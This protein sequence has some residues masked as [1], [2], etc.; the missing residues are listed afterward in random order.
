MFSKLRFKLTLTNVIV[1]SIIFIIFVMSIYI[2]MSRIVNDQTEQLANLIASN[3]GISN[4]PEKD[5]YT[6]HGE[7]QYRYFY[8][9]LDSTGKII[10]ASSNLNLQNSPRLSGIISKAF[11]AKGSKGVV[12]ADEETYQFLKSTVDNSNDTFIAFVNTHAEHEMLNE[13]LVVLMLAGLGGLILVFFGSLYM[14]NRSLIPIKEAW[15]RQKAFVADASHELRTPLSVIETT[16]D[17][18]SNRRENTI[19]SQMKWLENIQTENKRMTKLVSDLLLLARADS[20]QDTL[21]LKTFP[22]HTALLEAYI[23]FEAIAL[24]KGIHLQA[25]N[26]D[27][28]DFY[29]DEAKIKQLAVILVDNGIKYTPTGGCVGMTL[30]NSSDSVEI[31]VT[32]SGEG[33]SEE[34]IS[35]IFQRFY[36]IDKSRSRKDGSVGLG[37]SIAEWIVKQHSGHINVESIKGKGSTFRIYLP[38]QK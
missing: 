19:A 22:L 6:K 14:A 7:H 5:S 24:Q 13:L 35:K 31:C 34:H 38:K 3:A 30:K 21:Q 25:F 23:P 32:D 27:P 17:L 11:A 10:T 26:G 9:K 16:V 37:L 15:N 2:V 33:I 8:I 18:L 1:V 36:R 4:I 28:V 29:G 20:D 12:E